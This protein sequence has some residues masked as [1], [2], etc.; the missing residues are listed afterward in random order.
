[1]SSRAPVGYLALADMPVSI[2][3]G[4]IAMICDQGVPNTF[5]LHWAEANI[6]VIKSNAGGSTF[7]EISKKQFRPLELIVPP[8]K[9]LRT[10]DEMAAD[11]FQR[12][13]QLARENIS[14]AELR[15][16]L[17]PKLISGEIRVPEARELAEESAS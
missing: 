11:W 17:L 6:D 14:L 3:Q 5:V 1:M 16:R 10:F 13:S 4:F 7:A 2:N 9:L 12:V 8:E 15:D